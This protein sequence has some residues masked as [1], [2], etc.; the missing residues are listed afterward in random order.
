MNLNLTKFDIE[1]IS[2]EFI[3]FN[4]EQIIKVFNK[5]LQNGYTY[6]GKGFDV[7]GFDLMFK[8]KINLFL[9]LKTKFKLFKICKKK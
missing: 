4:K 6:Y 2:F 9:K 3:H 5:L 1:N 7:N 8:K